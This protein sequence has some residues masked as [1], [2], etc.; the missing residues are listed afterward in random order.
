MVVMK[1]QFKINLND[2]FEK[3][4][5]F[6]RYSRFWDENRDKILVSF[7]KHTNLRFKQSRISIHIREDGKSRAG[8]RHR[9][10]ELSMLCNDQQAVACTLIHEL[11]HRL[12]I[13]NGIE[14]PGSVT[15]NVNK[16]YLHRHIYLFLYDVFVDIVGEDIANE[17]V[18][19]ES[20]YNDAYAKAWRWALAMNYNERQTV[21]NKLKR[22]YI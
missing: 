17:E 11:A 12:V 15:N 8:S 18:K 13:G 5:A 10:M 14:P 20:V 3:T 19:R 9:P 2:N 21:F 6:G 7:Y 4:L 16:Y 22:R 1:L